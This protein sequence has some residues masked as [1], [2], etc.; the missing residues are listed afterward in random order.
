M[1]EFQQDPPTKVTVHEVARAAGVS[2]STVSRVLNGTARVSESKRATV[3]ATIARM[4]YS[5]NL[6]AQGLKKGRAMT[7][8]IVVQ[9][10]YSPFFGELLRGVEGELSGT[11]YASVVVSGHWDVKDE[12]KSVNLL[13]ARQ[14]DG[15][16]IL[17]GCLSDEEIFAIAAHRCVVATGRNLNGK[18]VFGF[19]LDN[20][21][22]AYQATA[23]LI[24]LGHQRIVFIA[25]PKNHCDA[26]DRLLGYQRAL[27]EAGIRF[28]KSLVLEGDFNESSGVLA[29]NLLL[30]SRRNF[31]AVF[32][33]NDQMAYGVRLGLFRRGIRVPDD[34]SLVGFDDLPGSSFTT[35]PLTTVRQPMYEVGRLAADALIKLINGERISVNLP[36]LELIIRETT[37]RVG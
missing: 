14:V 1:E 2:A 36:K 7:L 31:T 15:I 21:Y 20:E 24:E 4:N 32:S 11:D 8:G 27:H 3:E 37:R 13:L 19:A 23:H 28:D 29:V 16:I 18:N 25:G 12:L 6:L 35:P 22:G 34:I 9:H 5:P 26:N 10:V 17:S 30:E 33:T